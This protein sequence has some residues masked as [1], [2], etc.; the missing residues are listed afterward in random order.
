MSAEI[1]FIL[2]PP[3]LMSVVREENFLP[4]Y[5]SILCAALPSALEQSCLVEYLRP[6][7]FP[8]KTSIRLGI[9]VRLVEHL[10]IEAPL[11]PP[12]VS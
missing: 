6:E 4:E 1:A 7:P 3:V 8:L 12:Q 11:S 5:I 10:P 2:A 9:R